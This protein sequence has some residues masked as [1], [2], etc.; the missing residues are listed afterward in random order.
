MYRFIAQLTLIAY[1][2]LSW[3]EKIHYY[4]KVIIQSAPVAF[5]LA[6]IGAWFQENSEFSLFLCV[7][8][9]LNMIVGAWSHTKQNTF[10]WLEFFQGNVIMIAVVVIVYAM[11]EMLRHT[12]GDNIVGEAFKITI[13]LTT[14]LYPT[15]KVFKNIFI[16]TAG[17]YP[18]EFIMNKLYNFE[19]NGDL[20][21]FFKNK[22][23]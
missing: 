5:I 14:L 17:K 23:E 18:P 7:A 10:S 19:K 4:Y 12:V 1:D 13:Q 21:E 6:F 3:Q 22:K 16:L 8:L 15:S 2:N 11:L 9:L 20:S